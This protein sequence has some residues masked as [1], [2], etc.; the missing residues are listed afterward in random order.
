MM[1]L[2]DCAYRTLD[3]VHFSYTDRDGF[4][5]CDVAI[6]VAAKPRVPAR[7]SSPRNR[8]GM[9]TAD[10][11][12]Q[13]AKIFEEAGKALDEVA[14][15]E[16]KVLVVGNPA[17]TNALICCKS[18]PSIPNKNFTALSRLDHQRAVSLLSKKTGRKTDE[19]DNVII[20]GNHSQ[21]QFPDTNFASIDGTPVREI[22]MDD[23]YFDNEFIDKVVQR[24]S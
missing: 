12:K 9:E 21:S 4:R 24:D 13:N 17:M 20:W 22:V 5:D 3:E 14:S 11:L 16:V 10:L 18:A 2:D 7:S 15:K 8:P 19:I 23:D 6:L 1:E